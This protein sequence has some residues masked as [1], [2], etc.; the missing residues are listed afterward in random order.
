MFNE[1][2]SLFEFLVLLLKFSNLSLFLFELLLK[3]VLWF[4]DL[5]KFV[6]EFCNKFLLYHLLLWKDILFKLFKL[7]FHFLN[8]WLKF[9]GKCKVLN[10]PLIFNLLNLWRLDLWT[11]RIVVQSLWE[12][13]GWFSIITKPRHNYS[14]LS[15]GK[16]RCS[17]LWTFV[18]SLF[19][20][21]I[22]LLKS[23]DSFMKHLILNLISFLLLRNLWGS[24][25]FSTRGSASIW[26]KYFLFP[27]F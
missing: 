20:I 12:R 17:L 7:S 26:S 27:I 23:F 14:W 19:K 25:F 8:F 24:F 9:W 16:W 15:L 2:N 3:K 6:F 10:F 18:F 5:L 13:L 4:V 22:S 21:S 11:F 1:V